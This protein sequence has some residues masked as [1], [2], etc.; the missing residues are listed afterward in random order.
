MDESI[1]KNMDK[2][3]RFGFGFSKKRNH[4]FFASDKFYDSYLNNNA[5]IHQEIKN[6]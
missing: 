6:G 1:L 4:P 2:N 5:S 3:E